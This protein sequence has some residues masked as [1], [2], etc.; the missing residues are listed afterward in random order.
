MTGI[1]AVAVAIP[2]LPDI[3]TP[4]MLEKQEDTKHSNIADATFS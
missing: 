1:I 3:G 2:I 4:I